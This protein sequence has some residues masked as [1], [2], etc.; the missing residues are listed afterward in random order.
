M[1]ERTLVSVKLIVTHVLLLPGLIFISQFINHNSFLMVT[2]TQSALAILFLAGYWEFLGLK[3]K[4][5]YSSAFEALIL[6]VFLIKLFSKPKGEQNGYMVGLLAI[7]QI[8]LLVELLEIIIV[9]FKNDKSS[10]EIEFPFKNGKYLITDG[11]NSRISRIMNY[12]FYSPV[13]K[14]NRT[15]DS[16]LF[17]T[18]IVKINEF[19]S[20][21][22]PLQN[23]DYPIFG[24]KVF[25]PINGLVIK[26]EN[27]IADNIP[28]SGNYPYNTGNTVVIKN[29]DKYL[30]L[31]HLKKD[32]IQVNVGD[33]VKANDLIAEAGNSGYTERPH[34]HMQLIESISDNFWKGHGISI[35]YRHKNLFKNRV[36][37]L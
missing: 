12:H 20:N 37:K 32:S 21:Y 11:G 33:S 26:V 16:M 22:L 35:K 31:G 14:K 27:N 24:E 3:F 1:N 9:I 25:C 29:A 4:W 34:L 5:I 19:K 18:D 17:A 13:H 15:N 2:I 6:I 28:F 8:Y 7:I 23:K 10:V 30:L 36:I